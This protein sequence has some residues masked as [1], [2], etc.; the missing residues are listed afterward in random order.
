MDKVVNDSKNCV[1][2][3]DLD[4]YSCTRVGVLNHAIY[5]VSWLYVGIRR[6]SGS[7]QLLLR[8]AGV[9]TRGS[10]QSQWGVSPDILTSLPETSEHICVTPPCAFILHP[11]HNFRPFICNNA[12]VSVHIILN[13]KQKMVVGNKGLGY[14]WTACTIA[15][16]CCFLVPRPTCRYLSSHEARALISQCTWSVRW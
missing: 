8:G 13:A 9:C 2:K 15:W 3:Q 1:D 14:S 4:W 12:Q 7:I 5:P 6:G 10:C 16:S 11:H